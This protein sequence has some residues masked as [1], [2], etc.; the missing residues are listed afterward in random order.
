MDS[1][2]VWERTG[3]ATL[4]RERGAGEQG[5]AARHHA[6]SSLVGWEREEGGAWIDT[7]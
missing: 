5:K 2:N 3:K 4:S 6:E 7:S 1:T